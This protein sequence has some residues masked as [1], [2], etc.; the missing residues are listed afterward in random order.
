MNPGFDT[1][2]LL[3]TEIRLASDKYPDEAMRIEF[4]STLIEELRA[5]PGV[6]DVAVI[7]QLPIRDPG[8]NIAVYAA[9]RPPPDPNDRDP[10]IQAHRASGVLRCH[11]NPAAP[12]PRD[13][14][15]RHRPSADRSW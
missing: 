11:G 8:N 4:F 6:T 14:C 15:V 9:D 3:T 12:W 7:N 13:R 5:I 2:N 10:S 1:Q